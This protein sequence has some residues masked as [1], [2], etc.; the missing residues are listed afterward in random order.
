MFIRRFLPIL[1]AGLAGFVLWFGSSRS[2]TSAPAGNLLSPTILAQAAPAPETAPAAPARSAADRGRPAPFGSLASGWPLS[3]VTSEI[4]QQVGSGPSPAEESADNPNFDNTPT[5]RPAAGG[6]VLTEETEPLPSGLERRVQILEVPELPYPVRREE[7]IERVGDSELLILARLDTAAAHFLA[8]LRPGEE[9]EAVLAALPPAAGIVALEPLAPD[10]TVLVRLAAAEPR[11]LPEALAHAETHFLYVEPDPLVSAC[12]VPNDPR[13]LSGELWA[14]NNTGQNGGLADAD[15]DA[16]IA[17]ATRTS[18]HPVVV[19]VI[20]TGMRLTH[21]DL[22]PNLWFNAGE[23]PGNGIDDDGNGVIDDVHG[24]NAITRSGSPDDDHGHGTHCAGTVAAVGD[25]GKGIVGVA[26]QA[27]LMP[28]KFLSANGSGFLSDAVRA[29]DY[30]RNNGAH[31]LSNSW[32]GGGY[33]QAL[34]DAIERTR[35]AGIIF[36]AAAGNNSSSNDVVS[37]HPANYPHENVVSV[38]A[39]T[40]TDALASFSNYGAG[41]VHLAAPGAAILSCGYANDSAYVTFS[42]TSMAAPHVAGALALLRAHFPD[43]PVP[44][45]IDR[46]LASTDRPASL[47]GRLR[48]QGR[49]N[50][51]AALALAE[52]PRAPVIETQPIDQSVAPGSTASFSVAASGSG[53]FTYQWRRNGFILPGATS[54]S[55]SLTDVTAANEGRYSVLVTNATASTVSADAWLRVGTPPAITTEP[56]DLALPPGSPLTLV[57][58][59]SGTGPLAYQWSR[60]GSNLG[61]AIYATLDLPN[62]LAGSYRLTVTSAYGSAT[63]RAAVISVLTPPAITTDPA[64]RSVA[65]GGST[66]FTAAASGSPTLAYQWFKDGVAIAGATSASLTRSNLTTADAGSYALRVT[67]SAGTAWTSGAALRVTTGGNA[68]QQPAVTSS[69][70]DL[71]LDP[72][73]S[74]TLSCTASGAAPLTC[75][76]TRDGTV[77][78]GQTALT[79]HIPAVTAEDA[80]IYTLVVTNSRGAAASRGVRV[81]VRSPPVVITPPVSQSAA[82]GDRV[83]LEVMA[84][85]SGP[86]S[87]AWT[88]NGVSLSAATHARLVLPA[89]TDGDYG[90]YGVTVSNALGTTGPAMASV[91]PPPSA[92]AEAS[93][94]QVY[95]PG[96]TET[97]FSLGALDDSL[98]VGGIQFLAALRSDGSWRH[99]AAPI[100]SNTSIHSILVRDGVVHAFGNQGSSTVLLRSADGI[101]WQ[102]SQSDR[103]VGAVGQDADGFYALTSSTWF[104]RSSN[105]LNW[106]ISSTGS[107]RTLYAVARG[108]G[109]FV[110]VGAGGTILHSTTGTGWSQVAPLDTNP[111][112]ELCHGHAGFVAATTGGVFYHSPDGVS[113]SISESPSAAF[114][115]SVTAGAGRY[116]AVGGSNT[117]GLDQPAATYVSLDGLVWRRTP[118]PARD[119]LTAVAYLNGR[120]IA[121]GG[122]GFLLAS[123]DGETWTDLSPYHRFRLRSVA[124][125]HDRQVAV[126]DGY[127]VATSQ[128]GREWVTERAPRSDFFHLITYGAGRWLTSAH[129]GNLY[130]STG[131]LSSWQEVPLGVGRLA[132]LRWIGDRFF[133]TS[134]RGDLLASSDGLGWSRVAS[135]DGGPLRATAGG[136]GRFVAVGDEGCVLVSSDG[137]TWTRRGPFGNQSF[138]DLAHG[139]G[140]FVVLNAAGGTLVSEDGSTW[141]VGSTG[142]SQVLN[143]IAYGASRFVAVGAAG[144]IVTSIDGLEWSPVTPTFTTGRFASVRYHAGHFYAAGSGNDVYRSVDGLVWTPHA[145]TLLEDL[146]WDGSMHLGVG[147]QRFRSSTNGQTWTAQPF[148]PFRAMRLGGIVDAGGLFV[149]VGDGGWIETSPDGQV[150]TQRNSNVPTTLTSV[151]YGGGRYVAVGYTGWRTS[152]PDGITWSA[153][154]TPG[155][156]T[157]LGVVHNGQRF[158]TCGTG[159]LLHSSEDGVVWT[160]RESGTTSQIESLAVGNGWTVALT[161]SG[162]VLR[163]ADGIV[164][165]GQAVVPNSRRIVHFYDGHFVV[166]Q[167]DGTRSTST[168]GAVWTSS[169]PADAHNPFGVTELSGAWLSVGDNSTIRALA[170]PPRITRQPENAS[171][172]LGAAASVSFEHES[173]GP[174]DISWT[175]DGANVLGADSATVSWTRFPSS[176]AGA[177]RARISGLGGTVETDASTL[178]LTPHPADAW[179]VARFGEHVFLNPALEDGVW[180]WLADPDGDGVSNLAAYAAGDPVH[181]GAGARTV[182]VLPDGRLRIVF[183]RRTDDPQLSTFAETTPN[184]A[185]PDA[186]SADPAHVEEVEAIPL[187]ASTEQVSAETTHS[188]AP[189]RFLRVRSTLG[190]G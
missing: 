40:R 91:S 153:Q 71:A 190:D 16:D 139:A 55:L 42:G 20:D 18:A 132:S 145:A 43:E 161:I 181:G 85:G 70:A 98:I 115:R 57:A 141:S 87:Y 136:G 140:R 124:A 148:T 69:P 19:A 10:E 176:A 105:G 125:R 100:H 60:D 24:Y 56:A 103:L 135:S 158:V 149:A 112:V 94:R 25:N 175:H 109:R 185:L 177:W 11:S 167:I 165:S 152:S 166:E 58:A 7:I 171:P 180:G 12:A 143:S 37:F 134:E 63:S 75:T 50:L 62:V 29:I 53:P 168:D 31:I 66:T 117:T 111:I 27:R 14:L 101:T 13:Y 187:D 3:R 156:P 159:G 77:L 28:V 48:S 121:V 144:T 73:A 86:L 49:L 80:G 68:Q 123:E 186:W 173:A 188:A 119:T 82:R 34:A 47:A 154:H 51:A 54:A 88:R 96:P 36:V 102:R 128:N 38:A 169:V 22:A 46:I 76:W 107:P 1:V 114:I 120:F 74:L 23:I 118:N 157:L 17:W 39:T 130:T 110:A 21:E 44:V 127:F 184:L 113:W 151:A 106:T 163:S 9:L 83:V 15:I 33:Y 26:W 162:E 65:S 142:Q 5:H 150:W 99:F 160:L 35:A 137:W 61:G 45:L 146:A 6:R 2:R 4:V 81:E 126:G 92:P 182:E 122:R 89:L 108:G 90:E 84:A 183:L 72:G 59:A 189:S 131:S 164:W 116:V 78:T 79:L 41:T 129:D 170:A 64:G 138:R 172:R 97:L 179:R 8:R 30:A 147:Y 178:T 155:S 95:P 174:V 32:G 93:W 104:A 67:N 52:V 133:A